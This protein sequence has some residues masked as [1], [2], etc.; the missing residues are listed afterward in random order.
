VPGAFA[1]LVIDEHAHVVALAA[2][3]RRGREHPMWRI[4]LADDEAAAA[5]NAPAGDRRQYFPIHVA[6]FRTPRHSTGPPSVVPP[7]P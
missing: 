4:E 7:T 1:A 2:G 3:P 5:A 6:P